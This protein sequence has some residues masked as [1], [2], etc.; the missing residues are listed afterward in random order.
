MAA[1]YAASAAKDAALEAKDTELAN[2]KRKLSELDIL[3]H[4]SIEE[5]VGSGLHFLQDTPSSA[6]KPHEDEKRF[7]TVTVDEGFVTLSDLDAFQVNTRTTDNKLLSS[8][9]MTAGTFSYENEAAVQNY[10]RG[11]IVD[12]VRSMLC[13]PSLQVYSEMSIFSLRPDL[14][15]VMHPTLG[16]VLV[17]EVK[18]PGE[19]VF[20]SNH[21][22]GQIYDYLKGKQ[23]QGHA[24]PFVVLTSFDKMAIARLDGGNKQKEYRDIVQTSVLQLKSSGGTHIFEEVAP[25]QKT[26]SPEGKL[27]IQDGE[28]EPWVPP[29]PKDPVSIKPSANAEAGAGGVC[30]G[31]VCYSQIFQGVNVFKAFVLAIECGLQELQTKVSCRRLPFP[32]EKLKVDLPFVGKESFA[33]KTFEG[34]VNYNESVSNYS[35]SFYL[36]EEIGVGNTGKVFLACDTSKRVCA[37]KLYLENPQDDKSFDPK[38]RAEEKRERK[39]Q[40]Q[41]KAQRE[42]G[43]WDMLYPQFRSIV[44]VLEVHGLAAL[45]M[46]YFAPIP[47]AKRLDSEVLQQIVNQLKKFV[48]KGLSYREVRWRHIGCS[49]SPNGKLVVTMLDMESLVNTEDRSTQVILKSLK[50]LIETSGHPDIVMSDLLSKLSFSEQ[51]M[52]KDCDGPIV[53]YRTDVVIT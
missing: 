34:E 7:A 19:V 24:T 17:V 20:T 46:P 41:E 9:L 47:K 31:A 6:Q 49:M 38:R 27:I 28:E 21:I 5:L 42:K 53:D 18:N 35:K 45:K 22:A 4:T 44:F 39:M 15:V 10:V 50:Q 52:I 12:V 13:E 26:S 16:L 40:A 23:R 32:N 1:E 29:T 3:T 2:H 43:L 37:L 14:I 30:V 25:K 36:V 48:S 8:H 11:L 33:W 51:G